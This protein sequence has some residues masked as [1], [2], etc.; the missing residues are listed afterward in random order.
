MGR[1]KKIYI[2]KNWFLILLSSFIFFLMLNYYLY[3]FVWICLIPISI[4][5]IKNRSNKLI[6]YGLATAFFISLFSF[7]WL[8]KY[9]LNFFIL[10]V[11]IVTLFGGILGFIQYKFNKKIKKYWIRAFVLPLTW[12]VLLILFSFFKYGNTWIMFAYFQPMAYPLGY[13]L[14][15]YLFTFYIISFNLLFGLYIINKNRK[16]FFIIIIMILL[17]FSSFLYSNYS[18]PKGEEIKIGIVQGTITHSWNWRLQIPDQILD[19]YER[20][21]L[22]MKEEKLDFIFWP[23]YA[24]TADIEVNKNL[25]ERIGNLA[26]KM[27]SYII[28]GA[29]SYIDKNKTSLDD[30]KTDRVFIFSPEGEIFDYYDSTNVISVNGDI[31]SSKKGFKIFKIENVSFN[32]GLCYEEYLRSDNLDYENGDFIVILSNNHIFD[33]TPGL[34]LVSMFSRLK[35]LEEKKYVIRATNTGITQI[36]NPYGKVTSSIESYKSGILIGNIYI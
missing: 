2:S 25:S 8:L 9:K 6:L 1:N 15:P 13:I 21:T 17:V 31:I 5:F 32:I 7:N 35:A 14:G 30:L 23:E 27:D 36:V 24:I 11:S 3:F 18:E 29:F 12:L 22:E 34:K 4:I 10:F 28:F 16:L 20:L 19:K 26:K 33:N